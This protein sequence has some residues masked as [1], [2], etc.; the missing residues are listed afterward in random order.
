MSAVAKALWER[1]KRTAHAIGTFQAH[2][3]LS[4]LY[5]VL[6]PPFALIARLGADPLRLRPST[7]PSWVTRPRVVPGLQDGGKQ[8]S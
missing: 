7:A 6:L 5:V 8:F 3:M 2:A 4:L 1:W